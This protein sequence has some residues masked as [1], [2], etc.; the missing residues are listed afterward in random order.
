VLRVA[1]TPR[2]FDAIGMTLLGGRTFEQRDSTLNARPVVMVN[3]TF[4][5]RFWPAE[6]PIGK[7]IR[8]PGGKRLVSGDRLVAR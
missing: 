8:Y 1:T 7:R 2:Y 6:S 5:K 3:E 4:A